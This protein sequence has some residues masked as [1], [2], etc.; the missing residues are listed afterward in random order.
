MHL[1]R[2]SLLVL[3]AAVVCAC[4]NSPNP[5]YSTGSGSLA[6]SRDDAFVY[7]VDTDNGIVAVVDTATMNLQATVKVGTAPERITVGP[8]DTLYVSNRGERTVSVIQ[9]G[10]WR[11][12]ARI[13]VGV[14][15]V[16]LAVT[17]D[18]KTL[19]V[20]NATSLQDPSTGTLMAIDTR[21]RS[22]SWEIAVGEEP[23]GIA[24]LGNGNVAVTLYKQG[25][26]ATIDPT[27]P[28]VIAAG[29]NLMVTANTPISNANQGQPIPS[30]DFGQFL[31]TFHP[32]GMGSVAV[33]PDGKTIFAT[34]LFDSNATIPL[35]STATVVTPPGDGGCGGGGG[36]GGYG[37]GGGGGGNV[38]GGIDCPP[39][40]VDQGGKSFIDNN[41]P[42]G[43]IVIPGLATFDGPS[44]TA[45]VDDI[46]QRQ[47]AATANFP[48]TLLHVNSANPNPLNVVQEPVAVAVEQSGSWVYIVNRASNN[49]EIL[50]TTRTNNPTPSSDCAPTSID[51]EQPW[52]A[53]CAAL[54]Q[55]GQGPTGIALSRDSLSAYVY[56]SFDHSISRLS[57]VNGVVQQ[58]KVVTV[59]QDTLPPGQVVG[60]ELFFSALDQRVTGA[61]VGIACAACHLEGREDGQVWH[62]LD[63]PRQTPG[64]VGRMLDQTAPYHWSGVLTTIHNFMNMTIV[65]RMGGTGL[66]PR[67][68]QQVVQF[69]VGAAAPDNPFRGA[70]L[71]AQQ[72]HGAQI[73]QSA[74]CGSCH[75][76]VT[77]TNNGFANVGS[78]SFNTSNPDDFSDPAFANGLNVPSLL[79]VSRTAPYLHSGE[80]LTLKERIMMTKD[81]SQPNQHGN[82]ADLSDQDVDDLVAFLKTL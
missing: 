75:S 23:R 32:R 6:L 79:Q 5:S 70:A 65:E 20:V 25:D 52:A 10:D 3:A 34:T 21:S 78:Q 68:E 38:G 4:G 44:S 1:M 18:N 57:K 63:G 12:V 53:P 64:L 31:E 29:T 17:P 14:E 59:A 67:D 13:P 55:V 19:Y 77:M 49:V 56:N 16:G 62:F 26:I 82:T 40:P 80:A 9:R 36:G 22:I 71:N 74:S 24:L 61:Q 69:I 15:P 81:S 60:R 27:V 47:V 43:T 33:A 51:T 58:D 66:Q 42:G 41:P 35:V 11:E 28:S 39:I 73:F 30:G 8:D 54:V 45:K 46:T 37:G 7:A 2:S 76:G 72:Q 50:P 48:A